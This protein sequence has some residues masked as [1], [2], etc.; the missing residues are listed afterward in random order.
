[1]I[2]RE[3][4]GVKHRRGRIIVLVALIL[5]AGM[6]LGAVLWPDSMK[7]RQN[8]AVEACETAIGQVAATPDAKVWQASTIQ[9]HGSDKNHLTVTGSF[10]T[11]STSAQSFTCVVD[12]KVVTQASVAAS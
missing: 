3:A 8:K 7:D 1:V 5:G 12:D 6:A 2:D 4:P 11:G 10:Y 9:V